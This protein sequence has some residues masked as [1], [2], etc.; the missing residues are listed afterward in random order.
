MAV[1]EASVSMSKGR[2]KFGEESIGAEVM[3]CLREVNAS[4]A[5]GFHWN[6]SFLSRW[7]SGEAIAA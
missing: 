7:V 2:V 5:S 4:W 1:P 3:A 6:E